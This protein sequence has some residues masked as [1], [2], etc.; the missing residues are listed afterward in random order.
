MQAT[1]TKLEHNQ[2]EELI[3]HLS[4]LATILNELTKSLSLPV[5]RR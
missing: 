1:L 2:F 5:H 3:P 4:M